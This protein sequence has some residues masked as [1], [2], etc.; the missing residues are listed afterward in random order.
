MSMAST[1]IIRVAGDI[2]YLADRFG[3]L[4]LLERPNPRPAGQ[5]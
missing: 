1:S 4:R 3:G 2:V 5:R